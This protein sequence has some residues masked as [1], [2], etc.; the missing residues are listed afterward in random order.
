M[1]AKL[2]LY[3]LLLLCINL[4]SISR[5][6]KF[7]IAEKLIAVLIFIT[8]FAEVIAAYAVQRWHNNMPIYHVYT[9]LEF[10]LISLYFNY[11]IKAFRRKNFGVL[12]GVIG[13]LLSFCNTLFLQKITTINSY[14]LMFEGTVI[15][16]YCL[17]SF[18]QILM[19]EERLPY[20]FAHFWMTVCFMIFWS[21]TFTCWGIYTVVEQDNS[22]FVSIFN[23]LLAVANF[24][25]YLGI[26]SIFLFYKKL[27]PSGG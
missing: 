16:G 6:K 11:S 8:V 10:F 12:L 20:R 9:P 24:T 18:H 15:I 22:L 2:I 7:R 13:V 4:L 19:D 3:I 1:S 26:A 14:F 5:W 25:F 27:I 23:K 21:A 17:L